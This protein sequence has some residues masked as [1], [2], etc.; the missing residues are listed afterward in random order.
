LTHLLGCVVLVFVAGPAC[1]VEAPEAD[2]EPAATAAP[3]AAET[4]VVA[5]PAGAADADYAAAE[6]FEALVEG[7]S[8]GAVAVEIAGREQPCGAPRQC[9]DDLRE[10]SID[11]TR[12]ATEE[13]AKLF[14]EIRILDVPYL[15][16]DD[17]VVALVFTGAF[18]ARLRDA[19]V[20]RAGL[21]P[22]AIGT[23]AGWRTFATTG[24]A[25]RTPDDVRGL[26]LWVGSSPIEA[27]LV[28][29]LG[30]VPATAA[31]REI[32]AE[33]DRGA[34]NGL[35]LPLVDIVALG[36]HERIRH[37]TLDR[38]GYDAALWLMNDSSH[39]ALPASLRRVVQAGFDELTR[40][41]LAV[42]AGRQADA[43]RSVQAAGGEVHLLSPEERKAF[44]MA[45]GRVATGYVD[46]YGHEWLVWLEG[47]IA[48]AER[49]VAVARGGRERARRPEL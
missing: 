34:V 45:A 14:P 12:A 17:A 27:D 25:V 22:V 42:P 16:E 5:L 20:A 19:L 49:E 39:Q 18:Y 26:T 35:T 21:R 46:T 36:L 43:V 41:T 9:L 8:R 29:A 23:S 48:E 47:A 30:A 32:E 44:L 1:G 11:V 6:A 37:V 15:F 13:V 3:V 28:T 24:P 4:L 40:L 38:H 10:G 7:L 2:S 33:L 31:R